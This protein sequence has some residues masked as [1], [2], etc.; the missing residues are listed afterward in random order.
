[1]TICFLDWLMSW[2]C[3]KILPTQAIETGRF[4]V[5]V[6]IFDHVLSP[7]EMKPFFEYLPHVQAKE[8]MGKQRYYVGDYADDA[9]AQKAMRHLK[10]YGFKDASVIASD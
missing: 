3:L 2:I 10:S 9:S 6:G 7:E 4:R 8:V 5:L 1:M